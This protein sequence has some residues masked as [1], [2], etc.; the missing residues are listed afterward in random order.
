MVICSKWQFQ[1]VDGWG[2]AITHTQQDLMV[3]SVHH[4]KLNIIFYQQS[5]TFLQFF[6]TFFRKKYQLLAPWNGTH[7]KTSSGV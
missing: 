4:K 6:F 2:G 7:R 1:S 3:Y 5:K